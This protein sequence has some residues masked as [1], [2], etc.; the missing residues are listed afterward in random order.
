MEILDLGLEKGLGDLTGG[1]G[2]HVE[3]FS[4]FGQWR[5]SLLEETADSTGIAGC[6]AELGATSDGLKAR[7]TLG[8]LLA[9]FG[10]VFKLV[11]DSQSFP[12]TS[13]FTPVGTT[14]A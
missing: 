1:L 7:I 11:V 9:R 14:W 10:S 13:F 4:V 12:R 5:S 6:N 2:A 3:D 8:G